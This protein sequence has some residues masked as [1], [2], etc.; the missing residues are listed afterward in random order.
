MAK[1]ASGSVTYTDFGSIKPVNTVTAACV[2]ILEGKPQTQL[3][4][5]RRGERGEE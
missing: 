3:A 4:D 5:R 2:F 1:A